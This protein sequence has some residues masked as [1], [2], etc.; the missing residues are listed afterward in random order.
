MANEQTA[1]GGPD[2]DGF[3]TQLEGKYNLPSGYL[4][5]T[6][7]IESGMNPDAHNDSGADGMF[8]FVPSTARRMGVNSRDWQSS[9]EGA[10]RLAVEARDYLE[11][12][13]GRRISA[14][15]MYLAHQQGSGGALKLLS[16]PDG[17]AVMSTG[18]SAITS[19]GGTTDMT[20]SQFAGLWTG[21]FDGQTGEAPAYNPFLGQQ[22]GPV[23]P[24]IS[25]VDKPDFDTPASGWA[26]I[27]KMVV[28][29]TLTATAYQDMTHPAIPDVN[30]AKNRTE[31]DF[32]NA[33]GFKDLSPELQQHV[34]ENSISATSMADN[35]ER[36]LNEQKNNAVLQEHPV[37]GMTGRILGG[38]LDPV[39]LAA[40]IPTLGMAEGAGLVRAGLVGER[41]TRILNSAID[42][43][44]A[45]TVLTVPQAIGDPRYGIGDYLHETAQAMVLGGAIGAFGRN[46]HAIDPNLDADIMDVFGNHAADVHM[47]TA[48]AHLGVPRG[49]LGGD[50]SAGAAKASPLPVSQ[51]AEGMA[52]AAA[53]VDET[54]WIDAAGIYAH[55][56]INLA[57]DAD[58]KALGDSLVADPVGSGGVVNR[59][60]EDAWNFKKRNS[61][62]LETQLTRS[63]HDA[64]EEWA[65]EQAAAGGKT[66]KFFNFSQKLD[67]LADFNR[68]VTKAVV[69]KDRSSLSPAMQKAA[70][71]MEEH[72]TRALDIAGKAGNKTAAGLEARPNYMH[73][74]SSRENMR[75]HIDLHGEEGVVDV[76][77]QAWQKGNPEAAQTYASKFAHKEARREAGWAVQDARK[78]AIRDV[79]DELKASNQN[80]ARE[81][82]STREGI[83]ADR[84]DEMAEVNAAHDD[85]VSAAKDHAKSLRKQALALRS[86]VEEGNVSKAV[87]LRDEAAALEA[88]AEAVEL[89]AKT[90]ARAAKAKVREHASRRRG[91]VIDREKQKVNGAKRNASAEVVDKLDSIPFMTLW[92]EAYAEAAE[93]SFKQATDLFFQRSAKKYVNTLQRV[94]EKDEGN[95]IR[96][97]AGEDREALKDFLHKNGWSEEDAE[98]VTQLM[99]GTP[100]AGKGPLKHRTPLDADTVFIPRGSKQ[101]INA[102]GFAVRDLFEQDAMEIARKYRDSMTTVGALAKAGFQNEAELRNHILEITSARKLR[103][104]GV[105]VTGNKEAKLE[106]AKDT[107]NFYADRIM[108]YPVSE[109]ATGSAP[110]IIARTLKNMSFMTFMQQNGISQLGDLPKILVR[111]GYANTLKAMPSI[112]GVFRSLRNGD[113]AG[114]D[115]VQRGIE[116]FTGVGTTTSRTRVVQRFRGIDNYFPR[117]DWETKMGRAEHVTGMGAKLTTLTSG[118]APVND[119]L[120][121]ISARATLQAVIDHAMG[122][123]QFSRK[124]FNDIGL[125]DGLLASVKA[126]VDKGHLKL[127]KNGVLDEMDVKGLNENW[128]SEIDHLMGLVNREARTQIM[129]TTPG[130]LPKFMSTEL[131]QVLMQFKSYMIASHVSNTL[132]GIKMGGWMP[133][134]SLVATSVWGLLVY[135]GMTEMRSIGKPDRE[136]YLDKYLFSG[137]AILNGSIGRSADA[138][139]IPFLVDTVMDPISFATG[140]DMRVF[141]MNRTSGLGSGLISGT[142]SIAMMNQLSDDVVGSLADIL[143][144]D[145][146]VTRKEGMARLGSIPFLKSYGILNATQA[147]TGMLPKS[148]P[149]DTTFDSD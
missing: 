144:S 102:E 57:G 27:G 101:G 40:T 113:A 112:M 31:D 87:K 121:Q 140:K 97:M 111:A 7:H 84:A 130:S 61:E 116:Y 106:K 125:D 29:S 46:S 11:P 21:K 48:A 89:G 147:V 43:G 19:N 114:R 24:P 9:A 85:V 64:F 96:G 44:M 135:A 22:A 133:V 77:A 54:S 118:T 65:K 53:Q 119:T 91:E 51:T 14:G 145:Q 2:Y 136:E 15:E 39:T 8:Q 146:N 42:N 124:M 35:I 50:S 88:E 70:K 66:A 58:V 25:P 4:K 63:H 33:N 139:A 16:D 148:E 129:E 120:L 149:R 56:D 26:D 103:E 36:A 128:A 90:A 60:Q 78:D 68:Q 69:M 98:V 3:F 95:F 137:K 104:A 75:R 71:A 115:S 109:K 79:K 127:A 45:S 72:N 74:A 122:G 41:A 32:T 5:R 82:A 49:V 143:R 142:A 23:M 86:Q 20:N 93:H 17:K 100:E 141:S 47:E 94:T 12:R 10:A 55:R 123:A 110:S 34:M 52:R 117:S 99:K 67:M 83:K 13:L 105:D 59:G 138:A 107:L 76:V 38:F 108:G 28:D 1:Q 6:A 62:A 81:A 80:A 134:H 37:V 73:M 18:S 92:N 30:W 131:G 126:M 132:R